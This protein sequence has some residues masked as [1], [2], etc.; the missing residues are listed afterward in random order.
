MPRLACRCLVDG[1]IALVGL[2]F[3]LSS[4][5]AAEIPTPFALCYHEV[6]DVD[7]DQKFVGVGTRKFV[8]QLSWL[9]RNGYHA[10]SVDDIL[11][12]Q[13]GGKSL[14]EKAFMLTFD[15]GYESF[16]TRVFPILKVFNMP[17]VIG[18]VGAWLEGGPGQFVDYAGEQLPRERFM[19]W[20]Q[21]REVAASGL[22]EI[23]NHTWD[24]H[25]GIPANPQGNNEPAVVTRRFD[26]AVGYE[27]EEAYRKRL[28]RDTER[29]LRI[30]ERETGR[31]PRVTI[32][33]YGEHSGVAV[34]ISRDYGMPVTMTLVDAP[35]SLE[36]L[37]MLPRHLVNDDPRLPAFVS[38]L[39]GLADI[40]P[41]RAIQVDLDYVYD[42]DA[43][44]QDR[45]LGALVQRIRDYRIS[46]VF[47][48][49]FADPTGDGLAREVYFPNRHLPVRADLFNRAAWQLR[50]RAH[51]KVWAWLPVLAFDFGA[52]APQPVLKWDGATHTVAVDPSQYRRL[53]P[54]DAAARHKIGELYEDLGRY[55]SVDGLLF[56]DDATLS[57]FEDA[58]P[59]ALN[60]Y[61]AAG[62]PASIDAIRADPRLLERWTAFKTDTLIQL[63]N[64][65]SQ[66]VRLSRSP[67]HTA[68][69]I[70]AGP[71]LD[72]E[73]S[74]WFAQRYDRFLASYD[75]VAVMAMPRL[76]SVPPDD[77]DAWLGRLVRRAAARP[78]G[79]KRTL[80]ELQT[81]DWRKP[82]SDPTRLIP[83]EELAH[84]MQLLA[85]QGALNLGY[86]PDD[87]LHDHPRAAA[88]HPAFS[89]QSDPYP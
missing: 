15:D 85:R 83:D 82:T 23:A 46:T 32:W 7:P 81:V 63:T 70:Y 72:D 56:H 80:F 66:R 22:V 49:A 59:A 12:A 67:I 60:A 10:V 25:R 8:E 40:G 13:K 61:A 38:D 68:R 34:S 48:Q 79:I 4:A 30:I 77:T 86:Y 35:V 88:I 87:F 45:N 51:V 14:P 9:E 55:A 6:E 2:A 62:F 17:A 89:L 74:A 75:M 54:F 65:L 33:P 84:E 1:L 3:A 42:P 18:I 24:S 58:S 21:V 41:M 44:Q 64:E 57:D 69:N 76:E 11:A 20:G 73:S 28:D 31:R 29:N 53:S 26:P 16:Y 36:N 5:K 39:R 19:T 50:T 71:M 52:S 78:N 37:A 43:A 27:S 47:L